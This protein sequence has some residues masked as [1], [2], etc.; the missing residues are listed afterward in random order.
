MMSLEGI[1]AKYDLLPW[2]PAVTVLKNASSLDTWS[3]GDRISFLECQVGH[4]NR[5]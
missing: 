5:F 1:S 2:P 3:V 4:I